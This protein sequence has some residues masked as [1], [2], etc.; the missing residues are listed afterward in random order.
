MLP[1][2]IITVSAREPLLN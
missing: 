2:G 1:Y